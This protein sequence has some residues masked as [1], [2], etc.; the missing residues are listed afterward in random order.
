LPIQVVVLSKAWDCGRSLAGF[1]GS[2]PSRGV[3]VYV[4]NRCV[5]LHRDDYLSR[6]VLPIVVCLKASVEPRK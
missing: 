1:A 2:N 3:D 6:T 5:S 4:F